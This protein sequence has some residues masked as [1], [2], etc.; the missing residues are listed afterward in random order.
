MIPVGPARGPGAVEDSS[1]EESAAMGGAGSHEEE[2]EDGEWGWYRGQKLMFITKQPDGSIRRQAKTG[3]MYV[4][5][6]D[7]HRQRNGGH[8]FASD[9]SS[10]SEE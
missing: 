5:L 6:T 3:V 9:A 8:A 7:E 4:P 2:D 1:D 10:D